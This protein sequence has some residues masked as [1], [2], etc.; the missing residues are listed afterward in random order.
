MMDSTFRLPDPRRVNSK[1]VTT[2]AS[3]L[4]FS[5]DLSNLL[6]RPEAN[7]GVDLESVR[8]SKYLPYA[9]HHHMI[10]LTAEVSGRNP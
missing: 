5:P 4:V 1:Y 6:G 2:P 9:L 7:F 10:A 3:D 8:H